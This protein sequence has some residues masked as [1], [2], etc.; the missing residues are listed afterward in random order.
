MDS[1]NPQAQLDA[2][3]DACKERPADDVLP[4]LKQT[5]VDAGFEGLD[6]HLVYG[7]SEEI[8]AGIRP[9]A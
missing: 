2:V 7:W 1:P 9:K 5:L 6:R 3:F 8:S 4:I